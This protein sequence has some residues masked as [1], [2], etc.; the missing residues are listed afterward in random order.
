MVPVAAGTNTPTAPAG[1][2]RNTTDGAPAAPAGATGTGNNTT[3]GNTS[4][5]AGKICLVVACW[6]W[7]GS[8]GTTAVCQLFPACRL[9]PHLLSSKSEWGCSDEC[10]ALK[11]GVCGAVRVLSYK[12]S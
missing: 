2:T 4:S 1:T 6:L 8:L 7:K 10:V 5:I 11:N 9:S 12:S 3:N